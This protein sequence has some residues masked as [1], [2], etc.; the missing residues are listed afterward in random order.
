MAT[1]AMSAHIPAASASK[2]F[3]QSGHRPT[4]LAAFLYFDVAFMVWVMLG[5]LAPIISKEL[6]LSPAQKGF[7]VALPVLGHAT[8][9]LYRRLVDAG[10]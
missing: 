7:M 9:H 8:W 10:T 4:L 2:P 3:W 1:H 5:P 6:G